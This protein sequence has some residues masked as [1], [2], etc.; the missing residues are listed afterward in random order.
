MFS[1]AIPCELVEHLSHHRS[2]QLTITSCRYLLLGLLN[3][4]RQRFTFKIIL[5]VLIMKRVVLWYSKVQGRLCSAY[6]V[7][8]LFTESNSIQYECLLQLLQ[9]VLLIV[10]DLGT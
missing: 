9:P 2:T 8:R 3:G 6:L 1:R 4:F 7:I 5:A 10:V